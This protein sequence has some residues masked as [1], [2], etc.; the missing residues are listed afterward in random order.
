MAARIVGSV[1]W[2][3][4]STAWSGC[5]R[6]LSAGAAAAPIEPRAAI[7]RS[8]NTAPK[9]CAVSKKS[10]RNSWR[11]SNACVTPRTRRNSTNSWPSTGVPPTARNRRSSES[12]E[13]HPPRSEAG[14]ALAS[15]LDD[16]AAAQP[17]DRFRIIAE[18]AQH[19]FGVL[20]LIGGRAQLAGLRVAAHM[21][22]LADHL[23]RTEFRV[24]D[25]L[26]DPEMLD[27]WVGKG[28][29]D[30]ID[31]PARHAGFVEL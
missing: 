11:F 24:A 27:L 6:P 31:R 28:L 20:A 17:L 22:R 13:P 19:R 21:D 10:S 4:C 12:G 29:V 23:L 30:R 14:E 26:R 7:T 3:E 5:N 2:K 25:R 9:P 16:G 8:T 18:L 15:F 1:A